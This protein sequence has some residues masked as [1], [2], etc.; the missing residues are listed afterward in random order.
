MKEYKPLSIDVRNFNSLRVDIKIVFNNDKI[1]LLKSDSV[2]YEEGYEYL[3][4]FMPSLVN[5]LDINNILI[6]EEDFETLMNLSHI[7]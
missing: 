5:S 1:F 4:K 7:K 6:N 3:I 2:N